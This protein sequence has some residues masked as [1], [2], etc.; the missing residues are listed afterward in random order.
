MILAFQNRLGAPIN[1][2]LLKPAEGINIETER[3]NHHVE[4]EQ[5]F[6]S[7]FFTDSGRQVAQPHSCTQTAW[8]ALLWVMNQAF[9]LFDQNAKLGFLY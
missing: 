7:G 9:V 3:W 6:P 2:I 1:H 5:V 8:V 4:K